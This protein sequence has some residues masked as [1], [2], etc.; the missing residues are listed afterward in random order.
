MILAWVLRDFAKP[1]ME[2]LPW[3]VYHGAHS[4]DSFYGQ[5]AVYRVSMGNFL[6][7][8]LLAL[9][10]LGV[11]YKSDKRDQY[12]QH[13]GWFVKIA[14]W[15]ICNIVPFL[16]PAGFINSYGWVARVGSGLFLITQILMLLDFVVAW[17]DS[18][19]DKEDDRFLWGLL[20]ITGAAY[21]GSIA[22]VS[23]LFYYFKPAS[24]DGCSFNVAIICLTLFLGCLV[25]AVSMSPFAHNG[26]LFPAAV[27]TFYCTYLCYS[28]MIS[29]PHDYI[30]NGLGN[31]LDAASASTLAAGMFLALLS[32]VYSA[33]RAGS[34]TA[35]FG[36]GEASGSE[37]G[38][39]MESL[40]EA[41]E[42][43]STSAGLDGE[44][45]AKRT[46]G[47][48]AEAGGAMEEFQPVTY[49]Y[50]FFHLIFALAS[51]Y[52]AMLMTGWGTGAEE[53]D[54]IDV[55]WVSVWV[56][57]VTQWLTAGTYC[58]MLVAP[59]VLQDRTF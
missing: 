16:F 32:V 13:G 45:E 39:A 47:K 58:W 36:F 54:L 34:N 48:G 46:P 17:N 10:M 51:C 20:G 6:F 44:A 49:N 56:K 30:C 5:Q 35:L 4:S 55:G 19:V 15:I 57:I 50:S 3:L 59:S 14:L 7:F 23:V 52:I 41:Q 27:V 43:E 9:T 53:R 28:S 31:R 18:W 33:L 21:V 26:S 12:L 42:E 22:L 40:M 2:K 24:G 37:S 1:L 25:T 8:G 11:K 29:E 38:E